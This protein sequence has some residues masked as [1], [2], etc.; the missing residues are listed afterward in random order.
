M[1]RL[2]RLASKGTQPNGESLITEQTRTTAGRIV[3]RQVNGALTPYKDN[4]AEYVNKGY[5]NNDLVYMIIK[6]IVDKATVAPWALYKIVDDAAYQKSIAI[7]KELAQGT[8]TSESLKTVNKRIKEYKELR[9]KALKPV[10]DEGFAQILRMP[11]KHCT[12]SKHHAILWSYKLATGDYYELWET[13]GGG[14][15]AGQPIQWTCLPSH[16]MS[17]RTN[18]KWPLDITGYTLL[19]GVNQDFEPEEILHEA[20]PNLDWDL[21]GSQFYGLAPI[22]PMAKRLQR[23]NESQVNGTKLMKN[24]GQRG[25]VYIKMPA[26]AIK[27]DFDGTMATDQTNEMK[28]RYDE[29]LNNGQP[30]E[31]AFSGYE[32]GFTPIGLSPVDLDQVNLETHDFRMM[33]GAFRFPSQLLGDPES[34]TYANM[35]EASKAMILSCVLP[36]LNDREQSVSMQLENTKYKGGSYV[37]SADDSV[38]DELAVNRKD[39]VEYLSKADWLTPNEKRLEMDYDPIEQPEMDKIYVSS[40]IV[41]IEEVAMPP[42]TNVNLNDPNLDYGT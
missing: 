39:Q 35:A 32:T 8:Y 16:L 22:K 41:P 23:N 12:L 17:I 9:K 25:I 26:E 13:A 33:C 27:D 40:S 7:R 19:A 5:Q 24:G 3:A 29:I 28:L 18:Q 37:F 11:N 14:L 2:Q 10:Q 30:G 21:Q 34:K 36:L 6:A 31:T 42:E 4:K 20:Y 38:Y 1:N 15:R